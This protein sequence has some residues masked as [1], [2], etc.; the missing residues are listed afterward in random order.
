MLPKPTLIVQLCK[1]F[2]EIIVWFD[3]DEAGLKSCKIVVNYINSLFPGK[4]KALH[5]DTSLLKQG[6]KDPSDLISKKGK[7]ELIEFIKNKKLL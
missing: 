3:N 5:L 4:A 2:D 6:V 1:R 7:T